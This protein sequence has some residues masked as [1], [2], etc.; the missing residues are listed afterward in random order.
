MISHSANAKPF[1]ISRKANGLNR[2]RLSTYKL[3]N[4]DDEIRDRIIPGCLIGTAA[5]S[6]FFDLVDGERGSRRYQYN[7]KQNE[8]GYF[9]ESWQDRWVVFD[10]RMGALFVTTCKTVDEA[11][12]Y[13]ID[14][15]E[16]FAP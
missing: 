1:C 4:M 13:L 7:S 12:D 3:I 14:G 9:Y 2:I 8:F 5:S 11:T 15:E 10:N 16:L 6:C